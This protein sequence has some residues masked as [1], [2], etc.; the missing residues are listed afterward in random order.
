MPFNLGHHYAVKAYTEAHFGK[1]NPLIVFHWRSGEL[2][3][4]HNEG[5]FDCI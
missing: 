2:P 1:T 4:N 3:D 5:V